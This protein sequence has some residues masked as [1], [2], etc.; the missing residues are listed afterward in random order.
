MIIGYRIDLLVEN[1]VIVE[2]KSVGQLAP[3]HKAQLLTHLKLSRLS[4]GLVLKKI[5]LTL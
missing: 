1:S 2:P 4:L 5:D 3:I